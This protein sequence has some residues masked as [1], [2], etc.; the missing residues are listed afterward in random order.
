MC[1]QTRTLS[2]QNAISDLLQKEYRLLKVDVSITVKPKSIG[3]EDPNLEW[4]NVS[5]VW[6]FYVCIDS[7]FLPSNDDT[8]EWS[9]NQLQQ[10]MN[11][12]RMLVDEL[13]K[14]LENTSVM[15]SEW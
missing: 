2:N 15:S 3:N 10:K 13:V 12:M 7:P 8:D 11:L 14:C 5:T 6:Y 4:E 9:C 1:P